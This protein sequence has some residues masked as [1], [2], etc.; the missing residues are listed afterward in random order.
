M[1]IC[2]SFKFVHRWCS[3]SIVFNKVCIN[4]GGIEYLYGK[5]F[6]RIFSRHYKSCIANRAYIYQGQKAYN[7]TTSYNTSAYCYDTYWD[8]YWIFHNEIWSPWNSETVESKYTGTDTKYLGVCICSILSYNTT[9]VS[10][11]D[12][13]VIL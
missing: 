11:D 10:S 6:S 3:V 5:T 13:K 9:Y 2:L 12:F 7:S 4:F 8:M 1:P